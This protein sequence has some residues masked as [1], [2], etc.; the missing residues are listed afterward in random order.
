M[1]KG[2]RGLTDLDMSGELRPPDG[3]SLKREKYKTE[4][5]RSF[6]DYGTCRYGSKCQFAHGCDEL[7]QIDRHPKYRTKKC[8]NFEETGTCTY[9]VR[10]RFIHEQKNPEKVAQMGSLWLRMKGFE[11]SKQRLPV[12]QHLAVSY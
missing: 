9:G 11:V 8:K 12:F 3:R 1:G 7:R 2:S 4:M 5:C 6:Q 10:C